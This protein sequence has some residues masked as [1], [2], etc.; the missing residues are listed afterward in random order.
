MLSKIQNASTIICITLLPELFLEEDDLQKLTMFEERCV[1]GYLREK[2]TL[3]HAT[4]EEKIRVIG[5][6]YGI[7]RWRRGGEGDQT[8]ID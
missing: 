5:D 6:R 1:D 4:Q 8:E 3:L 7:G 2:D